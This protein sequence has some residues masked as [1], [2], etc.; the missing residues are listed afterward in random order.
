M[1]LKKK[2][3][4]EQQAKSYNSHQNALQ[5]ASFT[6]ENVNNHKEMVKTRLFSM[7]DSKAQ[8]RPKR[9]LSRT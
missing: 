2:K 9:K 5:Q 8:S 4:L 3:Q 1:A 6:M 7:K